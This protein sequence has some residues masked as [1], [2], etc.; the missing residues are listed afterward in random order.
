MPELI[1]V[2]PAAHGV[3][4]VTLDRPEKK[5][6]IS[7]EMRSELFAVLQAH[8]GKKGFPERF[9][10][11]GSQGGTDSYVFSES[12][13]FRTDARP[14]VTLYASAWDRPREL[15]RTPGMPGE[16]WNDG[17]VV[18]V[19]HDDFYHSAGDVPENTTDREPWN[20]GWCARAG[21]LGVLRWMGRETDGQ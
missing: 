1:R 17:D 6:A 10:T 7:T 14:A 9:A 3:R 8:E 16:S 21:W 13:P 5:N 15:R 18:H 19:D 2:D 12:K 4:Y 20:M 11:N